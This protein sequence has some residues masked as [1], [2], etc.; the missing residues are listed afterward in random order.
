MRSVLKHVSTPLV[1]FELS[2]FALTSLYLTSFRGVSECPS[3]QI[4]EGYSLKI[5]VRGFVVHQQ[6]CFRLNCNNPSKPSELHL[7]CAGSN[8]TYLYNFTYI[9][10]VFYPDFQQVLGN[11]SEIEDVFVKM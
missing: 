3:R 10:Y 5:I 8:I 9:F 11:V 7:P 6:V 2:N 4:P 1:N